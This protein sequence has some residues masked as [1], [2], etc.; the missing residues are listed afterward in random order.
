MSIESLFKEGLLKKIPP[1]ME[2]AEKSVQ[3][4]DMYLSEAVQTLDI[5]AYELV[6]IASYNS[7]FHAARAVLFADGVGERS[8]YAI[9]EYLKEKHA[10]LGRDVV[11]AF[12]MYRKLRHS[13]AYDLDTKVG[14]NDAESITEFAGDFLGKVRRHLKI[15]AGK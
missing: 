10:D 14:K 1:S 2:R 15:G 5:G 8:H 11:N 9:Y 12:D 3:K 7:I 6:I 4:A 13:V